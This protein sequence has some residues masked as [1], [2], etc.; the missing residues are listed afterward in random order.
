MRH[1]VNFGLLACF[2][3]LAV[4]GAL[5]YARPFSLIT[6]RVHLVFGLA[7][8]VL[9]GLHLAS[10]VPYF[11]SQFSSGSAKRRPVP[12][13]LLV[14]I[15]GTW[16]LLLWAAIGN[17]SP[18]STLV[19]QSYESRHRQEIVRAST[20]TGF[21]ETS[22]AN[23]IVTRRPGKTEDEKQPN[24]AITLSIGL[25]DQVELG[26]PETQP[27][28]AIWAESTAGAMIE[29][30]YVDPE[31][32]YSDRPTWGGRETP[33][34]HVLPLWRHRYSMISGVDP[35]G[36]VDAVSG[37]T[38]S[39][40]FS[41][42][43]YLVLEEETSF[44]LCVEINAPGDPN[45]SY[46]DPHVGQPSLLY[47]CFIELGNENPYALLELTGHGGS[48]EKSGAIHYD[49]DGFTSAKGLIDL[50]LAKAEP[51]PEPKERDE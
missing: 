45:D 6:T 1:I 41:L 30:L 43:H 47:T 22:A 9:V 48:A 42:D 5:A 8:L 51:L 13:A 14:G 18:V 28:L 21:A 10:R 35:T 50:L 31:L 39:H 4:S 33:R 15:A 20:L 34:H 37:A 49:L 16:I 27:A 44:V 46:Q 40:R 36:E 26:R 12:R 11:R 25:G 17:W 32:A 23:R 29:T 3:T 38:D 24:V 19:R 7:T 2:V